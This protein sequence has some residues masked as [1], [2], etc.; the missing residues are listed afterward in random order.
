MKSIGAGKVILAGAGPGDA[1]LITLKAVRYLR[2]A[3]VVLTDRLVN[4]AILTEHINP[5]AQIIFVG[6]E[7]CN[8]GA[9][10]SQQE[11][12]HLL[13]Q[14]ALE[15][16]LVV[17]LKGGDVAF[18][19]NVLD[20][21]L[22][23]NKYGVPYEIVPG[24]TAA[25]GAS[26]YSGIPLTARGYAKGVRFLT[27][28][29]RSS[30]NEHY[31]Q[32][33]A[34]TEDTLVFYMAGE[35]WYDLAGKFISNNVSGDKKLAI[36]QQATTPLQQVFV[37]EFDQL[38]KGKPEQSFVSPSLVIIGKVVALHQAFDWVEH[39]CG[40][41][42]CPESFFRAASRQAVELINENKLSA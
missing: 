5:Y 20:E 36:I 14:Y 42:P 10:I 29:T 33:L 35:S 37:H 21:L 31:W 23:L 16:K 9:S 32:D 1:E 30:Y 22:F 4:E 26:A 19:S 17:R 34:Q 8:N 2:E 15:G 18:F 27:F 7:G 40:H 6:K 12:N 39:T 41:P 28:S 13:V 11:I 24:V 38:K 25:S 3:D